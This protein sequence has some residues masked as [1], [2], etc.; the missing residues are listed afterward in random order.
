MESLCLSWD[1]LFLRLLEVLHQFCD[2]I[3][4]GVDVGICKP[5]NSSPR[6]AKLQSLEHK[7]L[8]LQDIF[9]VMSSLSALSY[10]LRLTL[11]FLKVH[12]YLFF[13]IVN[14]ERG[15]TFQW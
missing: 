4:K 10:L 9:H 13:L 2:D 11:I 3:S 15:M 7:K 6:I 5:R 12:R 8:S 14:S 1:A